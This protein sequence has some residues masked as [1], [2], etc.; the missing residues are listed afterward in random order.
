MSRRCLLIIWMLTGANATA[1][2]GED[3]YDL[4]LR[5]RPIE[6][7][8]L[9][10]YRSAARDLV[11]PE[12]PARAEL[13][14]ALPGLLHTTPRLANTVS[15]DGAVVLG[16]PQSSGTIAG[17]HLD[18]QDLG[19]EGF[20]LR[21]AAVDGHRALIVAARGDTGVL[22]GTF[23][24]LRLMQTRQSLERLAVH[25]PLS[26]KDRGARRGVPLL[27]HQSVF[28]TAI[29]GTHG[30]RTSQQRR[31]CRSRRSSLVARQ[32]R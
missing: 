9:A 2:H 18:L 26:G 8:W 13:L 27:R 7:P 1:V 21:S 31:P 23:E 19:D 20:L 24:L 15:R 16:T 30:V 17:L 32:S 22:Y 25:V 28:G 29:H 14:R 4:W 5:Y 3:G 11:A 12:G 10:Q 6:S